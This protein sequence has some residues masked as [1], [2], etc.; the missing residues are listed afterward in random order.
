[1]RWSVT[2]CTL[3][4]LGACSDDDAQ[5]AEPLPAGT[6]DPP[7]EHVDA[8]TPEPAFPR[9]V[10][11]LIGDGVGPVHWRAARQLAGGTLAVDALDGPTA[12][13]TDSL[14]GVTDSAAA[15]TA[16]ATGYCTVNG[17]LGLAAD[18]RALTT[19]FELARAEGKRTGLVTNTV[20]VDATP[21]G[22]VTHS[23]SR[24]CFDALVTQLVH[25]SRPNVLF[26][27]ILP[28][29]ELMGEGLDEQ[30][31]AAGYRVVFDRAGLHASPGADAGGDGD[32]LL[33]LFGDGPSVPAWPDWE[34]GLTPEALREPGSDEPTLAELAE[35]ALAELSQ[36]DAGFVLVVEDEH[37]DTVGHIAYAD[38]AAALALMPALVLELDRAV[39]AVLSW[40]EA[41]S[42][43]DET[44]VLVAADHETGGFTLGAA[45]TGADATGADDAGAEATDDAGVSAPSSPVPGFPDSPNHTGIP[46]LLYGRG[47]GSDRLA[48]VTHLT[49]IFHLLVGDVDALPGTGGCPPEP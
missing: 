46:V 38:P 18:G 20:A 33:G 8:G 13:A 49:D 12:Y 22:F 27:G 29:S 14:S 24:Y 45:D 23:A 17:A 39:A 16:M 1:V 36:G 34:Y 6:C 9:N 42:S 7:V 32:E 35:A 21:M 4:V 40:V 19:A 41:H 31:R 25:D 47:P 10:V 26:G 44:L 43:F 11:L 2:V 5:A 15:A 37:P 30:A 3:V 48:D 28:D